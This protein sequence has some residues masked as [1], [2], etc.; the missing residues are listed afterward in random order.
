MTTKGRAWTLPGDAEKDV[1]HESKAHI[2]RQGEQI[3]RDGKRG[4]GCTRSI[5]KQPQEAL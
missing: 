3:A 1:S 4:L 2:G 5:S